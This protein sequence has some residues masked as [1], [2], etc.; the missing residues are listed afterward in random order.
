[1][2]SV[3]TGLLVL[4]LVVCIHEFGHFLAAKLCGVEVQ[5][6]SVGWGPV[7]LRKKIGTTEYRLSAV[8]LGG[9]C[10]MKGEQ[11]FKDALEK[12]LSAIPYEPH[13]M[14]SVHPFKRIV[15]AFAGPFANLL[16]A[17]AALMVVSSIDVSYHTTDNRVVPAYFFAPDD[18]SPA[19][20]ADLQIGDRILQINKE[21]VENFSDIQRIISL[22]PE[23]DMNLLIERDGSTLTKTVRPKLNTKTGAGQ[24]GVYYYIPLNI[25]AVKPNSAAD[26]AGIKKGDTVIGINGEAVDHLIALQYFFQ[27]YKEKSAVFTIL[28]D[29]AA[30]D[31]PVALIRTEHGGIDLGLTWKTLTVTQKGAGFA[32][33]IRDG[34]IKTG[35]LIKTTVKSLTLLF[36]GVELTEAVA[37][38]MRITFMIGTVAKES[39]RTGIKEGIANLSEFV[40]II[41]I[42]LFLMNLLPIPVLDGGLILFAWI[43]WIARRQIHPRIL[44]YVQFIGIGFI[45]LLFSFAIWTDILFMIR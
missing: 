38:P 19:K 7:L 6:F 1:M 41:C 32:G 22:H 27:D 26:R 8:P 35:G 33:S 13:S 16:L 29:G 44:Y 18:S 11:A 43:E 20:A 25:D 23:E 3:I 4:G 36:R 5:T 42:S 40:A 9:Y 2:T 14:F 30:V 24:L 28:R 12:K 45:A 34:V 17:A 39:F 15:I 21:K 10:G 37:G 31:I